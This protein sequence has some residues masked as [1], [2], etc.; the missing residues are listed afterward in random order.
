MFETITSYLIDTFPSVLMS[1]RVLVNVVT[2]FVFFITALPLT[3]NVSI[4]SSAIKTA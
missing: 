4:Y 2:G 3:M 1:K